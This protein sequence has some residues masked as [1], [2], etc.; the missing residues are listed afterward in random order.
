MVPGWDCSQIAVCRSLEKSL[1]D[2]L[3]LVVPLM[4]SAAVRGCRIYC[5]LDNWSRTTELELQPT[6][7][8]NRARSAWGI[9]PQYVSVAYLGERIGYHRERI[10]DC[11]PLNVPAY[12]VRI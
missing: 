8:G 6:L 11:G 10:C 9:H 4:P 3:I 7:H 12:V 2:L 1:M 5:A